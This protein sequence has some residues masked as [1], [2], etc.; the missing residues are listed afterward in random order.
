MDKFTQNSIKSTLSKYQIHPNKVMGQNFL[1]DENVLDKIIEAAEIKKDDTILEV[2]PGLGILTIELAKKAKQVIA[3]EKDKELTRI[4]NN[5]LRIMNIK[6]VEIINEDILKTKY[7][8]QDTKYKIVANIPYYLTSPLIRKFLEIKNKP[9]L[10]VL[11]IQKEVAQRICARPPK[12]SILSAA[13]QFYAEPKII[14]H[15]SKKSFWP[16]PKVDS[17]ILRLSPTQNKKE[18]NADLRRKYYKLIKI[19]FKQPRKTILNNLRNANLWEQ[20][21]KEE[22]VKDLTRLNINPQ[23]RPQ[24]LGLEQIKNLSKQSEH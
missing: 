2:G 12:M 6:N 23:D 8:M 18:Q 24:N 22:I 15:V 5:E 16:Q 21:S 9:S 14:S 1:I 17:A 7:K 10:M 20:I 19:L 4:L 13:V 3:I 11:M